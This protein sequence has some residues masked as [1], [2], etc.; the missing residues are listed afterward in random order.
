MIEEKNK[1]PIEKKLL[2]DVSEAVA[3]TGLGINNV[4]ELLRNPPAEFVFVRGDR[5]FFVRTKFE[6]YINENCL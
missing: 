2:W 1:V 4:R 3:M 6:T 5:R